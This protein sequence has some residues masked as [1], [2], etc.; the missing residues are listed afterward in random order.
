MMINS[1]TVGSKT[2]NQLK[3]IDQML[4]QSR[5]D[6]INK[7]ISSELINRQNLILSKLLDAEKAEIERDFDEKRESKA[8]S[9]VKKEIPDG[10]FEYNN[11]GINENELIKRSNFKLRGF[12]DQK[13][14]NFLNQIKR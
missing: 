13:Y 1:S 14:N 4:E 11:K 7:R 10:Y 12:Y 8:A 5:V 2:S 9:D 3:A 6:L